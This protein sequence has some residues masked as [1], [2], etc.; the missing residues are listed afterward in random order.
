MGHIHHDVEANYFTDNPTHRAL[1]KRFLPDFHIKWASRRN[2]F[3]SEYS[4]PGGCNPD[5]AA[6]PERART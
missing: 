2:D 5:H 1:F 3:G 4:V 6:T